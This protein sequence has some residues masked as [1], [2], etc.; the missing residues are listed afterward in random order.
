VRQALMGL[1]ISISIFSVWLL[2]LFILLPIQSESVSMVWLLLAVLERTFLHTGLFIIAHDSMHGSLIS[3][4]KMWNDSIG[5]VAVWCYGLLSYEHCW[6]N[7]QQHHALPGQSGDPDFHD[8]QHTH[9]MEWYLKFIGEYLPFRRL[10][11]FVG[12]WG[13]AFLILHQVFRISFLNFGLFCILPLILSSIQLFIFGTYLPHRDRTRAGRNPMPIQSINFPV[14]LSFLSCYHF[15]YHR[16]HH[17]S[18]H[19]PWYALPPVHQS[20]T[21]T[22]EISY[23]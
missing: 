10:T 20:L 22:A 4:S 18:P 16:A 14:W 8:G 7:H 21:P 2:S 23:K 17:E 9:L 13:L 5:H 6:S 19:T 3:K 15:G 12:C 1:W 11:L